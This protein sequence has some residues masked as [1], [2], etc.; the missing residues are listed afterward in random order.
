MQKLIQVVF[1]AEGLYITD[2]VF[3]HGNLIQN[4]TMH[5]GW[6]VGMITNNKHGVMK[7]K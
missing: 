6:V 7:L 5:K 3:S 1:E 4:A 2:D